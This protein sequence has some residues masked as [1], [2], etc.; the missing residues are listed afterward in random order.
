M[1]GG[2][3]VRATFDE[4]LKREW[5]KELKKLRVVRISN[6]DYKLQYKSPISF[7]PFIGHWVDIGVV[8]RKSDI[9]DYLDRCFIDTKKM[10]ESKMVYEIYSPQEFMDR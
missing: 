6:D 4:V 3:K 8:G 7:I 9:K 5:S 2:E 10:V 1:I